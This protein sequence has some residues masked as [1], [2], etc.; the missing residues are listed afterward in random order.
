MDN[1]IENSFINDLKKLMK[2]YNV[3]LETFEET[4]SRTEYVFLG[5]DIYVQISDLVK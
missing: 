1:E 2:R 4:C 3:T 5:F